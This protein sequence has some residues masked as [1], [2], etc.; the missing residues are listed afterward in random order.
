[1]GRHLQVVDGGGN[2]ASGRV[3]RLRHLLCLA[4]RQFTT[5]ELERRVDVSTRRLLV[6]VN[7]DAYRTYGGRGEEGLADHG[8]G[9]VRAAEVNEGGRTGQI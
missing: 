8:R 9:R 1:M 6:R 5:V 3:A 7:V 2:E 4:P